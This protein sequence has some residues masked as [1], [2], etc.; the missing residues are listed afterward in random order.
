MTRWSPFLQTL[1]LLHHSLGLYSGNG[2]GPPSNGLRDTNRENTLDFWYGGIQLGRLFS[3]IVKHDT[4]FA[5][6]LFHAYC[7]LATCK[8][9]IRKTAEIGDWIVG[10]GSKSRKRDGLLIYAMRV[11]DEISFDEY[12]KDPRFRY[13][14]PD[15]NGGKY[16]ACGDNIYRWDSIDNRWC[17]AKDSFHCHDHMD[18]DAG[19]DRVLISDDYIYWGGSG[20]LLP[21]FSGVNPL[22]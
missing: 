9:R 8:P 20:P 1:S 6:N 18:R 10:T 14:R 3:Y 13:K 19:T 11:T 2:K 21:E 4:G 22:M 7:T 5:P 17:Q 15:K 12:W 16:R